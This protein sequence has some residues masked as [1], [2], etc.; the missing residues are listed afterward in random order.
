MS[1]EILKLKKAKKYRSTVYV[2][3]KR[4]RSPLFQRIVDARMWEEKTKQGYE[5]QAIPSFAKQFL[6]YSEK[7]YAHCQAWVDLLYRIALNTGMR[8]GEII[9][10][11]WSNIDLERRQICICQSFDERSGQMQ[12]STKSGRIRFVGINEALYWPLL[13]A[14]GQKISGLVFQNLVRKPL[15]RRNFRRRRFLPDMKAA[16]VPKIRFHDLRH[17]YATI[18]MANGGNI[19]DLQKLL[20]HST[21]A[22]TDRYAHFSPDHA[23]QRSNVVNLGSSLKVIE[24]GL[25][26]QEKQALG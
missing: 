19:Y 20:G 2:N 11:D 24:G 25:A 12:N 17:S 5:P 8:W 9:G 6:A 15:D 10:L 23:S 1:I 13:K 21:L 7:K 26:D 22:M 16:K 18:Y 14:K 3:G 4:F